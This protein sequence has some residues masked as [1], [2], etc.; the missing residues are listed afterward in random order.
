MGHW[1][2][3]LWNPG[4]LLL[5]FNIPFLQSTLYRLKICFGDKHICLFVPVGS[6]TQLV[7]RSNRSSTGCEKLIKHLNQFLLWFDSQKLPPTM[8]FPNGRWSEF[9]VLTKDQWV[10]SAATN[11][12]RHRIAVET[13][14]SLQ[15]QG[16]DEYGDPGKV[17]PRFSKLP[18][19]I[20]S[21][22]NYFCWINFPRWWESFLKS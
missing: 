7:F 9:D 4:N 3:L 22:Y 17:V 2:W 11:W 19:C 8:E 21:Y 5:R 10:R 12:T 15:H 6:N 14:A 16:I 18:D 1:F 13:N 20:N